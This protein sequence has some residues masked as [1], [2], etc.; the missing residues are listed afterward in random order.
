MEGSRREQAQKGEQV[1][2]SHGSQN[3]W[4]HAEISTVVEI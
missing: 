2:D 3:V 4:V 1:F